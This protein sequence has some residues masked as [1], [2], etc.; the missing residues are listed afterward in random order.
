LREKLAWAQLQSIISVPALPVDKRHNAK[1]D[2][3]KLAVYAAKA[4]HARQ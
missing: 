2:Y 4:G 3:T 1:F